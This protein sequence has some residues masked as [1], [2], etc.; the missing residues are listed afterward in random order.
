MPLGAGLALHS[1]EGA[2]VRC[3]LHWRGCCRCG[4]QGSTGGWGYWG[5]G[6]QSWVPSGFGIYQEGR[7]WVFFYWHGFRVRVFVMAKVT[8][9]TLP[10]TPFRVT[11]P[12]GSAENS[13]PVRSTRKY[14]PCE[15]FLF[16]TLPTHF[17][18]MR[19]QNAP[20]FHMVFSLPHKVMAYHPFWTLED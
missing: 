1:P 20:H 12:G 5:P 17:L 19:A 4:R 15:C 13:W 16:W 6:S 3:G 8:F 11:F 18:A 9:F 10:F 2:V 7:G 14:I